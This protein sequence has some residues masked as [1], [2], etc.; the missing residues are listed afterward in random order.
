M[1][2]NEYGGYDESHYSLN[3]NSFYYSNF[4]I[5]KKESASEVI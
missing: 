2:V 3:K 5:A 1:S 4:S